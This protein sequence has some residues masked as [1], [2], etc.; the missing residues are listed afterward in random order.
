M[1]NKRKRDRA[2]SKLACDL[3]AAEEITNKILASTGFYDLK[4][5]IESQY[6]KPRGKQDQV[7]LDSIQS[8]ARNKISKPN[9]GSHKQDRV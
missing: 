2:E 5:R 8:L 3:Q 9:V 7:W 1:T 4:A 6:G